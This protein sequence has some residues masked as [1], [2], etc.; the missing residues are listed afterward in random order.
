MNLLLQTILRWR[1]SI[2]SSA[3]PYPTIEL[4]ISLAHSKL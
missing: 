2:S 3:P 1:D 4:A